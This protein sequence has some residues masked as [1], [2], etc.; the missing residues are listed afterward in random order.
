MTDIFYKLLSIKEPQ[1]VSLNI[2]TW[3]KL[4]E[5]VKSKYEKETWD[6]SIICTGETGMNTCGYLNSSLKI[7]IN[8]MRIW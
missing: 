5:N 1:A 2:E 3:T 8:L 7:R 4:M 6:R